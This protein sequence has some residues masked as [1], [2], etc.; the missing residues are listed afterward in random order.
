MEPSP[1][2]EDSLAWNW[3]VP[4]PLHDDS[5]A[6]NLVPCKRRVWHENWPVPG[7]LHE[8]E[9]P[10]RVVCSSLHIWKTSKQLKTEEDYRVSLAVFITGI[11]SASQNITLRIAHTLV[12]LGNCLSCRCCSHTQP[13]ARTPHTLADLGSAAL[14]AAAVV[15]R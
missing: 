10:N 13:N 11:P 7:P 2:H 3:P 5:L 8:D 15:P 4:N 6:W 12:G 14:R 9:N 1:L